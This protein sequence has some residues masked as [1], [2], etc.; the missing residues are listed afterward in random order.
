MIYQITQHKARFEA[1]K[2]IESAREVPSQKHSVRLGGDFVYSCGK[3]FGI[4]LLCI[5]LISGFSQVGS[6]VS[7]F[8][9]S[10]ASVGNRLQAGVVGINLS[11]TNDAVGKV[12]FSAL[13]T[14]A[15]STV[16]SYAGED[17]D[18]FVVS[19]TPGD[20]SLPI[21]Y[22]VNGVLDKGVPDICGDLDTEVT[23]GTYGFDGLF[24]DFGV[25]ATSTMG[26]WLFKIYPPANGTGTTSPITCS[27]DIVFHAQVDGVADNAAH[28]FTDEKRYHFSLTL[29]GT[30]LE[31]PQALSL[32]IASST[33]VTSTT[34]PDVASSTPDTA[35]STPPV[36][37]PAPVGGGGGGSTPP[38]DP[39]IPPTIPDPASSTPPE[40]SSTPP[41]TPP[42]DG[43]TTP[44][45]PP[46]TPPVD[47]ITPP[48]DPNPPAQPDPTPPPA[49]TPPTDPPPAPPAPDP[50]PV[51]DPAPTL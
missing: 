47:P 44:D 8:S 40:T 25:E 9:D 24:K 15:S 50:A 49:E 22:S 11:S 43:T 21:L 3:I 19:V 51:V 33:D 41:V 45:V 36:E 1:A 13:T 29:Q 34:T 6:T 46:V 27:G 18:E 10:E 17:S 35:S 32:E 42:T 14:D 23:F 5:S 12:A 26:D 4:L 37:P 7:Y 20:D 48:T 2:P 16:G 38:V 30:P 31:D 28:A 39:I